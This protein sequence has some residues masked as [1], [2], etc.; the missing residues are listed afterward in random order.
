M[1][2]FRQAGHRFEHHAVNNCYKGMKDHEI[3]I[4][5]AGIRELPSLNS[6]SRLEL[7]RHSGGDILVSLNS[8]IVPSP[9]DPRRISL[10]LGVKYRRERGMII[11]TLLHYH[12][13]VTFEIDRPEEHIEVDGSSVAV[14]PR[15][16]AVMYSIA[17]GAIR[18]M[19]AQRT[20]HTVLADYPLPVINVSDIVSRMMY[21]ESSSTGTV[22]PLS[23]LAYH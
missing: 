22:I 23:E 20:A 14:T 4:R 11:R 8:H 6:F 21:G 7:M 1:P 15:L 3:D 5:I 17:V 18:G 13:E 19:L 2:D 10:V 9:T 12:I 16:M